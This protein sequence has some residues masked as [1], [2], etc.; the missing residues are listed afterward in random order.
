MPLW[1]GSPDA[2]AVESGGDGLVLRVGAHGLSL[3]HGSL[4]LRGDFIRLLPR[5]RDGRLQRELLVRAAKVKKGDAEP[6]TAVDATAGLGE[7]ALLLAAAG[8]K[9]RLF[10]CNPVIAALLRDTLQRAASVPELAPVVA[11]MELVEG[12]AVAGLGQ[13]PDRPDVVLLDPMFP[14]RRKSA[15]VKKKLQLLQQLE[16]PCADEAALLDAALAARP[17]KVVV[18]RPVKGA[19]LAGRKPSYAL[20]GKMVRYDCYVQ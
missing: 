17:H 6:H 13:L 20:T 7:D 5:I 15:Q 9:V 3:V 8:F 18:K 16:Q 11:R 1:K 2:H 4:E 12:D 19:C 14:A 10:E